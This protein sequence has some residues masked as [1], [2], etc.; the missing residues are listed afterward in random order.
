[1]VHTISHWHTVVEAEAAST[2]KEAYEVMVLV[3]FPYQSK[4]PR[5]ALHSSPAH[6]SLLWML[7]NVTLDR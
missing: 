3:L 4:C 1:M 2:P 7:F 6:F 5:I